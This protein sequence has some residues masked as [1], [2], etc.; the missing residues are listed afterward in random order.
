MKKVI[1]YIIFIELC[2][3]FCHY[4]NLNNNH[5]VIL[6]TD[7]KSLQKENITL[8]EYTKDFNSI[9]DKTKLLKNKIEQEIKGIN[10]LYKKVNNEV[11]KSFL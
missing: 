7:E 10:H 6:I 3:S 8:D 2:C 4:H 1:N 9:F 11:I 5:K